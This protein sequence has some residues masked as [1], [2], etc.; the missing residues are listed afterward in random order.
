MISSM[1]NIMLS[2]MILLGSQLL[3]AGERTILN[4]SGA[5]CRVFFIT[6][7]GKHSRFTGV[8]LPNKE[9]AVLHHD[10]ELKRISIEWPSNEHVKVEFWG[11]AIKQGSILEIKEDGN[12]HFHE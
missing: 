4:S 11:E 3:H 1:K 7:D 9:S 10:G 2:G 6:N 12:P 5:S 8:A